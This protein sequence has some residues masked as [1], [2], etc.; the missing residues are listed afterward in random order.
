MLLKAVPWN[1]EP[2]FASAWHDYRKRWIMYF[3]T[4]SFWGLGLVI[5]GHWGN[6]NSPFVGVKAIF[7]WLLLGSLLV[8]VI[9]IF[10]LSGFRCPNCGKPFFGTVISK[11]WFYK[12][13]FHCGLLTYSLE[14]LEQPIADDVD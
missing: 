11:P 7:T 8:N 14:P 6:L 10:R 5:A 1:S 3:V 12:N 13:C 2:A 9:C 4:W